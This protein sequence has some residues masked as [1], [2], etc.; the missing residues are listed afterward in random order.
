MISDDNTGATRAVCTYSWS[1]RLALTTA[2]S[3]AAQCA[4]RPISG[5][6][7]GDG[8]GEGEGTENSG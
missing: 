1:V 8:E 5:D 3:A 4:A 7:D 6:A 2:K